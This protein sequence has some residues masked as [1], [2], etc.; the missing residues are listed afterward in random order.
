M[1]S[2]HLDPDERVI[3]L[4]DVKRLYIA[5]RRKLIRWAFVG[6]TLTFLFLGIQV[7]QYKVEA[8]FKESPEKQDGGI[9]LKELLVSGFS[10][11][12]QPQA[13]SF[14]R[15][16]QV[17]RPLVQKM[18]L[19][20]TFP[21]TGWILPKVWRRYRDNLRAEKGL[22]LADLDPFVFENVVYDELEGL[23]FAL[24][25]NDAQQFTVHTSD[26]RGELARGVLGA[27]VELPEFALRFTVQKAPQALKTGRFYPFTI[28]HWL[29]A[30]K[31][32][33]NG[34]KITNDKLNKSIYE[35]SLL[36]R[37]RHLGTRLL[38]ELMTQYQ[39]YLKREHDELAKEQL[40]YLENKQGQLYA[41][42]ENLLDQRVDY[43][44]QNLAK[45]GVIDLMQE[46]EGLLQPHQELHQKILKIDIEF[47]RLN[48][49]EK[50]EKRNSLVEVGTGI[51]AIFEKIQDLK[52]QRD[53][54]EF[55]LCQFNPEK[56]GEQ[57]E[58][59]HKV[60]AQRLSVEN[61]LQEVD[62]GEEIASLDIGSGL[63]YWTHSLRDPEERED[64]AEYLENYARLLSMRE[65]MLQESFFCGNSP[66]PELEGIDAA[67]ANALFLEY[68]SKLDKAEAAIRQYREFKKE[69]GKADFELASLDSILADP[70]SKRII[71]EAASL[72]MQKKDERYHTAKE[73]KRFGEEMTLQKKVLSEHLD[74]L[75]QVE[76]LNATLIR[77]KMK[78][79]QKIH[80]NGLNQQISVLDEQIGDAIKERKET[81]LQEKTLLEKKMEELR[82]QA[83][84]LP[85]KWRLEKRL[86]LQTKM[87]GQMMETMTQVVE[88]K[89]MANH[90]HRVESK[91]LDLA[92]LPSAPQNPRLRFM[93]LLGALAFPFL[94][95]FRA[96][97]RH[98]FH[99][100]PVSLEKLQAL[101]LPTLGTITSFCDGPAVEMP[102][103]PDLELLR[104][105]A[106]FIPDGKVIG[107][108]H[109]RGPDYSYALG[110]NLAR[111]SAKS[112]ILRCDFHS[113]FKKEDGP[114]LLQLWKGEIG[115]V[116]IRKGKGFDYIPSGGYTP[117]ATEI[118][119]SPRLAELIALLKKNYDW[120]FL[121]IRAPLS[122]TE[123]EAALP[124][125]DKAIVTLSGEKTEEL[126]PFI[127][128]AYHEDRWRLTF[129][130]QT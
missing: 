11:G 94:I 18:G 64:F 119:Q 12:N 8:S 14:M 48:Q 6:G 9:A 113:K 16:Y 69:I 59:L 102:K 97:L 77:E 126:T 68:N 29:S 49:L 73:E 76:E 67:T 107:L 39:R 30:A 80:L 58:E 83:R 86:D 90:L 78:G 21:R 3:T 53:L 84:A 27:E 1:K 100:F 2:P 26:L 75:I 122:S 96:L 62:R 98:I 46:T 116:P 43:M 104:K 47:S 106:L 95:F 99:G 57:R 103:G 15:S 85:E 54:L 120:V 74:Q 82:M 45:G 37:D 110:E 63:G 44:A 125:C 111:L 91:P 52:Q 24:R 60:R 92:L 13:A 5:L 28:Q 89:T 72:N 10:G 118:L 108:I 25:F 66:P 117:H 41:K 32:I 56:L 81:L 55:S 129:V 20:V 38:N 17:L 22:P 130:T 109:G 70:F 101:R 105:I 61:L 79:L 42:L 4:S 35:I 87:T 19:N 115:E 127:L 36:N 124:L 31:G 88:S 114:G 40:V 23:S 34:I 33:K 112:I 65:K 123:S 121:L 128:W 51:N 50:E 93:V 71:G 7:P